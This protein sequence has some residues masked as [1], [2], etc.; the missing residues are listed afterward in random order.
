MGHIFKVEKNSFKAF[1]KR[2]KKTTKKKGRFQSKKRFGKSIAS[3]APSLFLTLLK[4]KVQYL[5]GQYIDVDP[6]KAK[7]S[8]YDH[9]T[10]KYQKKKLSDR[11]HTF[12]G[13]N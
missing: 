8:Q 11:W 9:K 5:G 7:P 2:K 10:N 6:R 13:W 4:N 12:D 1:Q 3:K